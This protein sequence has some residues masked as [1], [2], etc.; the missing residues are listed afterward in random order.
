MKF[1]LHIILITASA[2]AFAFDLTSKYTISIYGEEYGIAAVKRFTMVSLSDDYASKTPW[3][4]EK[5]AI[6]GE[7]YLINVITGQALS[8]FGSNEIL[9]LYPVPRAVL[10][11]IESKETPEQYPVLSSRYGNDVGYA[12]NQT[13]NI[14][15]SGDAYTIVHNNSGMVLCKQGTLVML[16]EEEGGVNSHLWS[17]MPKK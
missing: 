14:L 17:I 2:S 15:K 4:I 12:K 10:D 1:I 16:C 13:W 7:Y 9:G 5:T 8:A 11:I 3:M 6:D